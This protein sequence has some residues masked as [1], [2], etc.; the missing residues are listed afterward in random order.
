MN[1]FPTNSSQGIYETL[2]REILD[3]RLKPGQSL[4]ENELCTRFGVSRT[5]VRSV[6]QRLKEAGLVDVV[7][8]KGTSVTLLSMDEIQQRIY[9]RVAIESMVL[10]DFIDQCTPIL[11]EKVR[12]IIRKQ[13]VLLEGEFDSREFYQLDSQ[14]HE[15]W[16]RTTNKELLWQTIQKSQI[17]YTRFRML[18]IVAVQNYDEIVAEHRQLF[19]IIQQ[20]NKNLVEPWVKKHMYGGVYRLGDRIDTDFKKYFIS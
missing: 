14:L 10:R 4:S 8:Y 3:L 1:S 17:N 2:R 7:P 12:Y 20:K 16:F 6:L 5:P 15:V 19:E 9:M 11:L 13:Q 18:D